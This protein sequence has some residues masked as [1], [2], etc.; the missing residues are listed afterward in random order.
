MTYQWWIGACNELTIDH[1]DPIAK[2]PEYKYSAVAMEAISN[3][4]EAEEYLINEY[5]E[6]KSRLINVV[7]AS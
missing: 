5:S 7:E 2:T 6:L 3:Q 4:K 1:V